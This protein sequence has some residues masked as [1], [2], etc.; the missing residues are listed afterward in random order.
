MPH[1]PQKVDNTGYITF[2]TYFLTINH[3]RM[4]VCSFNSTLYIPVVKL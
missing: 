2:P 3:Y 1:A 4:L